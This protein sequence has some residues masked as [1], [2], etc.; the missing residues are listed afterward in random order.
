MSSSRPRLL[1]IK[2]FIQE[3]GNTD[4]TV[5]RWMAPVA[6]RHLDWDKVIKK[7]HG[8]THKKF[9]GFEMTWFDGFHHCVLTNTQDLRKAVELM[10]IR[11]MDDNCVHIHVKALPTVY[12]PERHAKKSNQDPQFLGEYLPC[13]LEA[14]S[15]QSSNRHK[16]SLQ[17]KKASQQ[18]SSVIRDDSP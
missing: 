18:N 12:Q 16:S 14:I 17:R 7:L 15:Q 9:G 13:Y 10:Q 4:N 5:Y 3:P 11:G 6:A 8:V 1:S 2:F